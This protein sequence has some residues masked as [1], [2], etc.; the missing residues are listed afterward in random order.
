MPEAVLGTYGVE[1]EVE[2]KTDSTIMSVVKGSGTSVLLTFSMG[3][4]PVRC[5]VKGMDGLTAPRQLIELLDAPGRIEATA[6]GS[7]T[8]TADGTVDITL[9]VVRADVS[10]PQADADAGVAAG[11]P[12]HI[13]GT[14]Q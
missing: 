1:V 5:T 12:Y 14:R 11:V 8:I 3:I 2:G 4:S 6:Q 9:N 13:T 7:G 10:T